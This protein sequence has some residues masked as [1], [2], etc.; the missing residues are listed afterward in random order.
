MNDD[1]EPTPYDDEDADY[2]DS[3][4]GYEGQCLACDIWGH[5]DDLGLCD[6]CGAK[7]ERDLIRQR[8][9]DY[10]ATAFGVSPDDREELRRRVIARFGA[11]LELITPPE[12]QPPRRRRKRRKTTRPKRRGG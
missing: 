9:W 3:W 8:D 12:K 11:D 2:D 1:Y 6:G 4:W 10:S 7:L 5:V